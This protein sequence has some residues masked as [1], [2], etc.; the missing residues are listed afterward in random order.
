MVWRA[1][2]LFL[3][4]RARARADGGP[5]PRR[6]R[7]PLS[8]PLPPPPRTK[9]QHTHTKHAPSQ[10]NEYLASQG[11]P[12]HSTAIIQSNPDQSK[13]LET[14]RI[15]VPVLPIQQQQQQ[16]G[17]GGG[18]GNGGGGASAA[19]ASSPAPPALWIDLVNLRSE[20]YAEGSRIPTME[21]GTPQQDA[22]R[23]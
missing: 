10:V 23:R 3:C 15:K 1:L 4:A 2:S 21:F 7:R 19:A 6:S 20:T 11:V 22:E 14:A 16:A 9:R 13:H 18:G 5:P 12:T 17:G 8:P